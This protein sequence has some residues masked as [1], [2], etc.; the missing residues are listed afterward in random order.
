MRSSFRPE[1]V[2]PQLRIDDVNANSVYCL[3]H[4]GACLCV[5]CDRAG[6]H[7]TTCGAAP[8]KSL[9]IVTTT[10][11]TVRAF[12]LPYVDRLRD[13]GWHVSAATSGTQLLEAAVPGFD[14]LVELSLDRNLRHPLRILKSIFTL[15]TL[16]QSK[17]FSIVHVHTPIAGVVTRLAKPIR[18]GPR[19]IYTAHGFRFTESDWRFA[20]IAF[21]IIEMLAGLRTDALVVI[22]RMDERQA[23]RLR[24]VSPEKLVY[25][26]GI[27]IDA[28]AYRHGDV[29]ALAL[30]TELGVSPTAKIVLCVAELSERKRP[31]DVLE[32]W[33]RAA[34][35]DSILVFVGEGPLS[36]E[37]AREARKWSL[38]S[39]VVLLGR[40]SDVPELLAQANV[41]VLMSSQEGLPR[42]VMEAMA[43]GVPIIGTNIRG[44]SDLLSNGAG[45]L[46]EVGD[47]GQLEVAVRKV[48][49][50]PDRF[51]EMT[52]T[53]AE[54]VN[55]FDFETVWILHQKLYIN[56]LQLLSVAR[57]TNAS[58]YV[59]G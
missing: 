37:V 11:R 43:A 30:R 49:T 46:I 48:L 14:E 4:P 59:V 54:R 33:R 21:R 53:A 41:L 50:D 19:I 45:V 22:N 34:V 57:C 6:D 25:M 2:F 10:S 26:P 20:A 5:C 47:V 42:C 1:N 23:H 24:I 29:S 40:R 15:Y 18:G 55:A 9:L 17:R 13:S 3:S 44:T 39:R 12:L 32:G 27:G 28:H 56:Q 16:M 31:L 7:M 8:A 52:H 35:D 51:S 58:G 38:R 36:S